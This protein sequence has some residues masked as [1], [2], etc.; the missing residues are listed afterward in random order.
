MWLKSCE[1]KKCSM[2]MGNLLIAVIVLA[3]L[4]GLL[5][6]VESRIDKL[7]EEERIRFCAHIVEYADEMEQYELKIT[8]DH[9]RDLADDVLRGE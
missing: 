1:K 7:V 2:A 3:V 6:W 5:L 4:V 8:P 9:L